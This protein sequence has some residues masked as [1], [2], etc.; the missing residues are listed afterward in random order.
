MGRNVGRF[1]RIAEGFNEGAKARRVC[2]ESSGSEH[3]AVE[4]ISSPDDLSD[5]VESFLE[6]DDDNGE[7][8]F[9]EHEKKKKG[10]KDDDLDEFMDDFE[11]RDMLKDLL[12]GRFADDYEVT[13]KI[14]DAAELAY[15]DIGLNSSGDGFKRRFMT[16]LRQRGFD[17][18]LCKSR[19]EKTS[20]FLAG[21]FE[22]VDVIVSGNR[23]IVEVFLV[24]EFT[25]ARPTN[26]YTSLLEVFP[27]IYVGKPDKL[28]QVVRIMCQASNQSLKKNDMPI[29]PWR[30]NGYMQ[31]KWLSLYKRTIN[32]VTDTVV[33]DSAS[34]KQSVGFD[35]IPAPVKVY[36]CR[37]A[38]ER[39]RD[40]GM[41]K[42]LGQ[43]GQLLT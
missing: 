40:V 6:R 24:G 33:L 9:K 16:R 42:K 39:R 4:E 15:K 7:V 30:R 12:S 43:L 35:T 19:W 22:Y 34:S 25:I 17:A 8:D 3:S 21:T 27:Q 31:A 1:M 11:T 13:R 41:G 23:Y 36:Y 32:P 14:R 26:R 28:K 37:D 18:G 38:L 29:P 5:L 10:S 20:R 2:A